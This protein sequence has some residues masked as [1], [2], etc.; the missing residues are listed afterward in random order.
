[1]TRTIQINSVSLQPRQWE[2]VREYAAANGLSVSAA[3]RVVISEWARDRERER[4][5]AADAA[6]AEETRHVN[7]YDPPATS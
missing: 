5:L 2:I 4:A 1:M 3:L 6:C 7:Y